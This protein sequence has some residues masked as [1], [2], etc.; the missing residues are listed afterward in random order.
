MR[1]G[2]HTKLIVQM[3]M[4]WAGPGLKKSCPKMAGKLSSILLSIYI[5]VVNALTIVNC[6]FNALQHL[7]TSHKKTPTQLEHPPWERL[8]NQ[9]CW[10]NYFMEKSFGDFCTEL[11]TGTET[12]ALFTF[13]RHVDHFCFRKRCA[14]WH[15]LS[16]WSKMRIYA[17][18]PMYIEFC[19]NFQHMS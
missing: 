5:K 2:S 17:S 9:C 6:H 11:N 1:Q 3:Y 13:W 19:R 10:E 15:H 18:V 16:V 12:R 14:I 8:W 4:A 7:G